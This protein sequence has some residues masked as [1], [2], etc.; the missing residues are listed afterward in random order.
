MSTWT[1][2][3]SNPE[4]NYNSAGISASV[5]VASLTISEE[6]DIVSE[7]VLFIRTDV[8][9]KYNVED[10]DTTNS[11]QLNAT[12]TIDL[13]GTAWFRCY[14]YAKPLFRQF[15]EGN[16][17]E[18]RCF[19][20]DGILQAALCPSGGAYEWTMETSS[21]QVTGIA[22]EETSDYGGFEN[23]TLWP[24][25]VPTGTTPEKCYIQDG[26]VANDNDTLDANISDTATEI[27]L[28]TTQKAFRIRGWVKVTTASVDEWIYYD[29]YDNAGG[30][31]ILRNCK[32]GQLGTTAATHNAGDTARSK[33]PKTI[34]P[35]EVKLLKDGLLLKFG[36]QYTISRS[37]GCFVVGDYDSGATYTATLSYYD[38]DA[39]LD[40]SSTTVNLDD[41]V[42]RMVTG[43]IGDGGAGFVA[44]DLDFSDATV[45]AMAITRYDYNP[46]DKPPMALAAIHD[47]IASLNLED[48]VKFWFDHTQGKF[49]LAIPAN[50]ETADLTISHV[51]RIEREMSLEDVFSGVLISYKHDQ[52]LN[53]ATVAR[54]WH[55]AATGTGASPDDWIST[56]AG[57]ENYKHGTNSSATAAGTF[58]HDMIVD[59][60][61]GTKLQGEF[62]HDPG[63]PFVHSDWWFGDES[64]TPGEIGL[65]KVSLTVNAYQDITAN[66]THKNADKEYVVRVLGCDDYNTTTHDTAGNGWQDIGLI[67]TGKPSHGGLTA[68]KEVTAFAMP[69]VNALRIQF[70]YMAAPR[71]GTNYYYGTVHG[72]RVQG[73]VRGFVFVQT[74]GT[75]RDESKLVYAVD[76]HTK[77]RGGV[78][79]SGGAGSPRVLYHETGALSEGAAISLGRSLLLVKLRLFE[80]RLYEHLAIPSAKPEL[81][82]TIEIDEDGDG[83]PDY[84]GVLRGYSLTIAPN[85]KPTLTLRVLDY[86][87]AVIA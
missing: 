18:V 83:S 32:R 22:L 8:L 12:C 35:G 14:V 71:S 13:D 80:E 23:S 45:N 60:D 46:E 52:P 5:P 20:W 68:S 42:E 44:G 40:G 59:G 75:T 24:D 27:V 10:A 86:D 4:E 2:T 19:G 38:A 11:I 53:R 43:A 6:F 54:S 1:A 73:D 77:L 17:L 34:A 55:Q 36:S 56:T 70:D 47:L 26:F 37:E 3:F 69:R 31:Y 16:F 15:E 21:V 39:Q 66:Q 76:T 57:G 33:V 25:P 49:R 72:F 82:D 58:G 67:I 9:S 29:G 41:V 62:T 48:E 61:L 87:A 63:N 64:P 65:D 50:K 51:E 81:G 7:V 28:S 85:G 78:K 79:S 84:T 30:N 74:D